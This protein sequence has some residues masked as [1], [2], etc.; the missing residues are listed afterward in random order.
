MRRSILALFAAICCWIA[1]E[2]TT[3]VNQPAPNQPPLILS[4]SAPARD[5]FVPPLFEVVVGDPN[6]LDDIAAVFLDIDSI[7]V[8]GV[9]ARPSHVL[10]NCLAAT[11][12]PNDTVAITAWVPRMLPGLGRVT[13]TR[14][15]GGLFVAAPI[16][17]SSV[18]CSCGPCLR[19][20]PLGPLMWPGCIFSSWVDF[21]SLSPP[22]VPSP[23]DVF[24]TYFDTEY[25][26]IRATV[27]D[28]SGASATRTLPNV[29]VVYITPEERS[30]AP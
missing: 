29:R 20:P 6:G 3:V 14:D 9:I 21:L 4:V 1:C 5:I 30:V 22:A 26:G 13:M 12:A 11:Y 16:C 7:R 2:N 28:A 24:V 18:Q 19:T 10:G 15:D 27:Y 8:S 25:R 17:S 23:V